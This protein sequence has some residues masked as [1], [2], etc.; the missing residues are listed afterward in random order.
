MWNVQKLPS[1]TLYGGNTVW[2]AVHFFF[3]LLILT[4]V[5]ASISHFLTAAL[6]CSCYSSNEIDLL[7]FFISGSS[8]FSDMHI[9]VDIKIKSE[10][11]NWLCGCFLSLKVRVAM[12][13]TA[14]TCGY[15]KWK[16][17]PQLTRRVDIHRGAFLRAKISWMHRLPNFFTHGAPLRSLNTRMKKLPY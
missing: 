6:K 2:G 3:L 9:N 4:L 10:E 14:K 7:C 5:A 8:S 15:L 1:Y 11:K 17:S 13:F 16:I 12:R